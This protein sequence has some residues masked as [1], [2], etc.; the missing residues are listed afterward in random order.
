VT[1]GVVGKYIELQ[2]AYKS[3][4][5]SITHAGIANHCKVNVRRIDAEELEKRA[6]SRC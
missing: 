2:D 6:G 4:Y 3:V 1:I 5:E